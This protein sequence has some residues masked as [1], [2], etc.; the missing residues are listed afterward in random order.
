[1]YVLV[2]SALES[3]IGLAA[4][5]AR[6]TI[7]VDNNNNNNTVQKRAKANSAQKREKGRAVGHRGASGRR[8]R[9]KGGNRLGRSRR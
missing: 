2:T 7:V 3:M 8:S 4:R 1:M 9:R 6:G 5:F